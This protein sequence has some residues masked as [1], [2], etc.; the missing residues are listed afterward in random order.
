MG[1]LKKKKEAIEL[2]KMENIHEIVCLECF[3]KFSHDKV[4]FFSDEVL[5]PVEYKEA[6]KTYFRGV[7]ASLKDDNG[8]VTSERICPFCE[9]T[10]SPN[11]GYAPMKIIVL[12]G[13]PKSG[14][15]TYFTSLVYTL[16]AVTSRNFPLFCKPFSNELGYDFRMQF[17]EP[18]VKQGLLPDAMKKPITFTVSFSDDAK[19]DVHFVLIE[20]PNKFRRAMENAS[21]IMY[22]ADPA[23]LTECD[24]MEISEY[25]SREKMEKIPLGVVLTKADTPEARPP[26]FAHRQF[27][28]LTEFREVNSA[29]EKF[30]SEISPNFHNGIK[31]YFPDIGFFEVSATGI[32]PQ[33]G[34]IS[35]FLP[36]H[37]DEP[38][39][40]IL[41]RLGFI[42][43][44]E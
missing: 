33:D 41:Y 8:S 17:E 37:V 23:Q 4:M 28:N 35:A 11:A 44:V 40:W 24:V 15:S 42:E 34:R 36:R 21:A 32:T 9:S 20:N 13:A 12:I 19:T 25:M 2:K 30:V 3:Q 26:E 14:K 18:L 43:S 7:L 6:N 38:F 29:T 27:F 5:D 1:F 22:L 39:L 31:Q 10:L 16:K